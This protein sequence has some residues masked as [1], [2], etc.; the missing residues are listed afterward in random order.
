MLNQAESPRIHPV[1]HDA[2]CFLY[3]WIL[4]AN[5]LL[6]IVSVF[7]KDIGLE[8]KDFFAGFVIEV[9]LVS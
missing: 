5:S 2:F 3:C 6:R 7:I 8:L 9:M 4:F 1:C